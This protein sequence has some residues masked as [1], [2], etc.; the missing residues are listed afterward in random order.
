MI[1]NEHEN[2]ATGDFYAEAIDLEAGTYEL[3]INGEVWESRPLTADEITARTP[4]VDPVTD[5]AARAA[6][7]TT[8]G[9]L[10][11]VLLDT[12]KHLER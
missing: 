3:T 1:V 7:A 11:A 8:V 12:L 9:A 2:K 4:T 5:L 6:K 10:R